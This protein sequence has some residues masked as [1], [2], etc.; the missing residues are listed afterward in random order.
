MAKNRYSL[1]L[2]GSTFSLQSDEEVQHL[3]EVARYFQD[4]VE[5]IQ[6]AM[7]SASP[8]KIAVLAGLNLTDE[9]LAQRRKAG[10]EHI[11]QPP[12]DG[13]IGRIAQRL[14]S[15][16]DQSLQGQTEDPPLPR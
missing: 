16:I 2:F 6:R 14:I 15:R 3:G 11:S 12:E 4:R 7:P 5:E 10:E 9:L 8:V 13:D 1:T